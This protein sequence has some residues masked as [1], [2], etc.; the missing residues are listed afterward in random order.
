MGRK[1]SILA[2]F[3]EAVRFAQPPAQCIQESLQPGMKRPVCEAGHVCVSRARVKV[4][5]AVKTLCHMS[6]W[7]A[8]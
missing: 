4:C 6:A 5:A 3:K 2:A 1:F 8:A 7:R